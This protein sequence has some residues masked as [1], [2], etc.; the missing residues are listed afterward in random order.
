MAVC[1]AASFFVTC[2]TVPDPRE[3]AKRYISWYYCDFDP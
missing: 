1:E 2:T 3:M